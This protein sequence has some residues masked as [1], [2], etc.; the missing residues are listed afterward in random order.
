MADWIT[1]GETSS[2]R[3]AP[4]VADT[5]LL[6]GAIGLPGA[7]MQCVTNIAPALGL[8]FLVQF[9]AS[10]TGIASPLTL[11]IGFVLMLMCAVSVTQLARNLPSAGG[12]FT[13][14]SRTTH[15]RIGF[16]VGWLYFIYQPLSPA[17]NPVFM[18]LILQN[19]LRYEYHVDFPWWA[20]FLVTACF[21]A[22]VA[23]RGI[24]FSAEWLI[25]LGVTEMVVVLGLGIWGL[26]RPGPGGFSPAS[27]PNLH[28]LYLGVVASLLVL[29]GWENGAPIAEET[30]NPRKCI[31][32]AIIGSV[33]ILG[34]LQTIASWG[35]V[36][37]WGVDHLRSFIT[38]SEIPPFVLAHHYWGGAWIVAL[39]A[40]VNSCLALTV[41]A[42]TAST[43]VAYSMAQT[44]ALPSFLAKVHP[45]Y[46]TPVNA[47]H[48]QMIIMVVVGLG[49]G[50]WIGPL[51]EWFTVSLAFTLA[52]LLIYILANVG[53]V[54]FYRTEMRSEFNPWLHAVFPVVSAAA[55]IW[56][57]YKSVIPLPAQPIKYAPLLL[58]IWIIL[59]VAV[60]LYFWRRGR[61]A[62]MLQAVKAATEHRQVSG[63]APDSGTAKSPG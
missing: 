34:I 60:L 7:L 14:L 58:A 29:A 57:G 17:V 54:R 45:R 40:L 41:S 11:I 56:V 39:L 18:G 31:P 13:Y 62:W 51:N 30:R 55:F 1:M 10:V 50:F 23:Y 48:V 43:R 28:G 32:K 24:R 38:S 5:K 35:L 36:V 33:L 37:G 4:M 63:D 22:L 49:V 46:K 52:L 59:G 61:E 15:P 6:G 25:G 53:V 3:S 9:L 44:G 47:I 20:F 27:A 19:A 26:A 16:L 12:F 2:T 8:W 42:A 21:L